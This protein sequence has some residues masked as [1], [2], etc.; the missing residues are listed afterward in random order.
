MP[1]KV[2]SGRPDGGDDDGNDSEETKMATNNEGIEM[3][4]LLLGC[5][6][7]HS[8]HGRPLLCQSLCATFP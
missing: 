8:E 3:T 6:V 5:L 2:W 7:L 1:G 4:S